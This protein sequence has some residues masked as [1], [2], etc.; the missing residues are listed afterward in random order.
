M[1]TKAANEAEIKILF[2]RK[3]FMVLQAEQV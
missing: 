1:A 3:L 2:R